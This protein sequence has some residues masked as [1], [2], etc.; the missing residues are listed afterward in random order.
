VKS[1]LHIE[2]LT[3]VMQ[4]KNQWKKKKG[5][6]KSKKTIITGTKDLM[7]TYHFVPQPRMQNM[8]ERTMK[9]NPVMTAVRAC[10]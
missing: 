7:M 9:T 8:P 4:E 6:K 2:T 1:A 10:R 5:Q 3:L